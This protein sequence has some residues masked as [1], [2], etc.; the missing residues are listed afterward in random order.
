M[1]LNIFEFF[2]A[3]SRYIENELNNLR[4]GLFIVFE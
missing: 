3:L 2:F 1:V 4:L